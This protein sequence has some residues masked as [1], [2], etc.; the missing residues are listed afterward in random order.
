MIPIEYYKPAYFLLLS[1]ILLFFLLPVLIKKPIDYIITQQKNAIF[2]LILTS[3]VLFIGLRDINT[4]PKYLG[5]TIAYTKTFEAIKYGIKTEFTKDIGFYVFMK[6]FTF[7]TNVK[8]FYVVCALMYCL[9]PYY[10]FKKHFGNLGVYIFIAYVVSFSFL[11]FG[12]NG[13]RNGLAVAI[14]L[15]ALMF[16]EKK[17]L[18][19]AMMLLSVSFHKAM[20]LPLLAF[21]TSS[22]FLKKEKNALLFWIFC[23]PISLFFRSSLESFA[24]LI[25]SSDSYV[26]DERA[27]TYFSD[28]GQKYKV[29]GQ[30]RIDFII[31]SAIAIFIG[32][33]AILKKKYQNSLYKLLFRTYLIANGIWILL[34]YAP[35]TNRIAYLSWFLM[36]I[37]L[38]APFISDIKHTISKN[39]TKLIYVIFGSLAFTL[40][41]EFI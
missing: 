12:I 32:Y 27:S 29:S 6:F 25:F 17:W 2:F 35:Y 40:I 5:D 4:S 21:V 33:W 22:L 9:L 28:E 13:V 38:T 16:F 24:E 26:Q 20:L 1:I 7:F 37:I 10:M 41:M 19:Y 36:P 15:Y 34:I 14:F 18:M 3:C 31:Y 8:V 30:F 39:Q 11:P 23:I